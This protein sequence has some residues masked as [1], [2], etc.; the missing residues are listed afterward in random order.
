MEFSDR[1][2]SNPMDASTIWVCGDRGL[3]H[4]NDY[5]QE[6]TLFAD[7]ATY[8]CCHDLLVFPHTPDRIWMGTDSDLWETLNGGET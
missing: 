8:M 7:H 6:S 3:R 1:L 2:Y 4:W 5:L